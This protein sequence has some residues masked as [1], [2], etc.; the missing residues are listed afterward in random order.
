[1][2]TKMGTETYTELETI[3]RRLSTKLALISTFTCQWHKMAIRKLKAELL[4][5][6]WP[7]DVN[8]SRDE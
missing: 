3:D 6:L 5:L 4:A 7:K 8:L 1:M 2:A